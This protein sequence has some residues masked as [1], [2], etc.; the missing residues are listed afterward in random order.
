[1]KYQ[2]LFIH[3]WSMTP[4]FW[5]PLQEH[6]KNSVAFDLGYWGEDPE[7]LKLDP[8]IQWIGIGHSLG[9]QKLLSFNLNFKALIGLQAFNNFLGQS[10]ELQKIRRGQWQS[11]RQKF[12]IDPLST[13]HSFHERAGLAKIIEPN[14]PLNF[15]RLWQDLQSLEQDFILPT[16]IPIY[17]LAS[18]NDPIVPHELIRDNFSDKANVKIDFHA[19]GQHALGFKEATWVQNKI[20]NFLSSLDYDLS[21]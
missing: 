1:M 15:E 7:K 5:G 14:L 12:K 4:V 8:E 17:I 18:Q 2:F 11:L 9:F 16:P 6:F 10:L 20:L 3:G 19:Q 13:L 21:K